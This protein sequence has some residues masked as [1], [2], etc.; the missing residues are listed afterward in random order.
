MTTILDTHSMVLRRLLPGDEPTSLTVR[1]GQFHDVVIG[2]DRVVYLPRTEA[3]AARMPRRAAVLR[4]LAGLDLGFRTPEPLVAEP[5]F[6]VVGRVPGAP[7]AG[8]LVPQAVETVAAQ[9]AALLAGLALAGA[10]EAVRAAL[11]E[12]AEDRWRRFADDVREEL[13]PLMSER[14]R[15]RAERELAALDALPRLTTAVVHG[16][17]GPENVLWEKDADGLPRLSGVVDW[18]EVALGDPAEDLAAI[19]AGHGPALLER[20][21]APDGGPGPVERLLPPDDGLAA[22]IAAIQGTFALQQALSAH[23]DGDPEE[24]ADGLAGYR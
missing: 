17:L 11:P 20:V 7:L 14:G 22:R 24:L 6:L 2:S 13:F 23:R 8:P 16:D 15:R 18:D 3:A 10:E 9:Y 5:P 19:G 12:A 1:R 4:V 21:L